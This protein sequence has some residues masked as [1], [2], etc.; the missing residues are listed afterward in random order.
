[1]RSHHNAVLIALLIILTGMVS[2]Q[3]SAQSSTGTSAAEADKPEPRC[4]MCHRDSAEQPVHAI[5]KTP[6]GQLAGGGAAGCVA[7]HGESADHQRGP[8]RNPPDVSFGPK[9]AMPTAEGNSACLTCHQKESQMFWLGGVHEQEDLA[10]TDCHNAHAA[11]DPMLSADGF[12]CP[13]VLSARYAP[14]NM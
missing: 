12:K 11:R 10:C 14:R 13:L 5:F 9:W 7:C 4:L 6:H 2:L 3:A 8:T 1:M